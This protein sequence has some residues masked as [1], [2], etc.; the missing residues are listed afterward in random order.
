[1]EICTKL[2]TVNVDLTGVRYF[3]VDELVRFVYE[4]SQATEPDH[5]DAGVQN[6]EGR[7]VRKQ[8]ESRDSFVVNI[9]V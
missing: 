8:K 6:R 9:R 2:L 5:I 1:V 7:Q 4:F 3:N